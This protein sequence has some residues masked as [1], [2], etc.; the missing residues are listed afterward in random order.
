[1]TL[2]LG[3][4]WALF[5]ALV[6]LPAFA[7]ECRSAPGLE[8]QLSETPV[9]PFVA[10]ITPARASPVW[11]IGSDGGFQMAALGLGDVMTLFGAMGEAATSCGRRVTWALRWDGGRAVSAGSFKVVDTDK[12]PEPRQ[13]AKFGSAEFRITP[14]IPSQTAW[15]TA[16]DSGVEDHYLLD[17]PATAISFL[18]HMHTDSVRIEVMG[19]RA[20][21]VLI[22]AELNGAKKR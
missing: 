3:L 19:R 7:E 5:A 21:G 2:R 1:M 9:Q 15:L 10:K 6:G 12:K 20:D 8:R 18:P 13:S 14:D 11:N 22:Y 16:R 17:F 4:G